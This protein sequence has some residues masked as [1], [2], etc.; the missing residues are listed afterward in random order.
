VWGTGRSARTRASR[1][2]AHAQI[3]LGL[4]ECLG[5]RPPQGFQYGAKHTHCRSGI[6]CAPPLQG[7]LKEG[8]LRVARSEIWA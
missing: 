5:P 3:P 4:G 7:F 6:F 2:Y 1:N 8:V